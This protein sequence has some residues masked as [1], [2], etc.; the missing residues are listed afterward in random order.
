[1]NRDKIE[2]GR[3]TT[4]IGQEKS[5][6]DLDLSEFLKDTA[7]NTAVITKG[8]QLVDINGE[9]S[10]AVLAG[11][12]G[13]NVSMVYQYR[14]DGKLPPNSDASLRD[15]IKHHITFWKNKSIQKATG[16]SEA[17]LLQKVQLD[18]ARTEATWLQIKRDRGEL[19]DTEVLAQTFEPHFLH[20]RTQLCS[21]ARKHPDLQV[22]LD[23]I[24]SGWARLGEDMKLQA[25]EE[26][27]NFIQTQMEQEIEIEDAEFAES[28]E[29]EDE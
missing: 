28:E 15:C 23:K 7:Q 17:A 10:P 20:M 21:L 3:N 24:M 29:D 1:M 26:L 9:V 2:N 13:C 16:L 12:L 19:V 27:S 6:G 11:L 25:E 4:A 14:Q 22:E 5:L 18:R 8:K